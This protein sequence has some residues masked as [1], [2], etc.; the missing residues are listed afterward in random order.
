ML[1][2][3]SE[4]FGLTLAEDLTQDFDDE[5]HRREVVVVQKDA[6]ERRLLQALAR[7][8]GDLLVKSVLALR[9]V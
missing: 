9:H 1:L 5:L 2:L 3:V 8:C 6:E 7:L 4:G